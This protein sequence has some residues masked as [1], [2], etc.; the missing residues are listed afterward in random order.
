MPNRQRIMEEFVELAKIDSI[1]FEE[2]QMADVLIYKLK[3]L[4][5]S[6]EEDDAGAK[7]GGNAGN[8]IAKV[9]GN[10]KVPSILLMAHMDTVMPGKGKNPIIEGDFIKSDGKTVL[11]GDDVAGI[12]CILETLRCLK[13]KNISHGDIQIVFSIAEEVGLIGAKNL[14]FG[15]INAKYGFVLDHGGDIGCIATKAPSQNKIDITVKGKA[16]HAGIEPEKGVNA[17]AI[18]AN[19]ISNMKLGRIDHETTANIGI[20]NGGI[21]TNIICDMVT[22]KAEVRSGNISKLDRVTLDMRKCL[23]EAVQKFGG[24]LD[25]KSE[26]VYS[27]FDIKEQSAIIEI[28]KDA[29]ALSGIELKLEATGGGSDTNVLNVNGIESVNL[30]I[31][32][33]KVHSIEEQIN[34]NDLVKSVDFLMAVIQSV[35]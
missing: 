14:D 16:A 35:K 34:I 6:A 24:S 2:R 18:A 8:V 23:E 30:S 9:K 33:D 20:I 21:A 10:K 31:A 32:M 11:G 5:I 13:E 19:A 29:S 4:G 22:L 25:F 26:L 12:E 27:S 17:I 15:K 3:A 28:L 1:S 7:T